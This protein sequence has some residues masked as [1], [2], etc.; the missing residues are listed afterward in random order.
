L[1]NG[2]V[3]VPKSGAKIS[4]RKI[5]LKSPNE[6]QRRR[7]FEYYQKLLLNTTPEDTTKVSSGVVFK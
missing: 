7:F 6:L 3:K 5:P 1:F 4:N 2:A